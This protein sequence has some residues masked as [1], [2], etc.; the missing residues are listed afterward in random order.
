MIYDKTLEFC[1]KKSVGAAITSDVLDLKQ[2]HPNTG[3][4]TPPFYL[5]LFPLAVSGT[6]ETDAITFTLEDSADNSTFSALLSVTALA[7]S[8]KHAVSIPMPVVHRRYL[9]LTTTITG[10]PKGTL[11]AILNNH[12][13]ILQTKPV[14]GWD[15][16]RAGDDPV[17][18]A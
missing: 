9:R 7:N 12:I 6:S 16:I 1:E 4:C 15:I 8:M 5:V 2:E 14:E 13:E 3:S 18:T 10:T 17:T 11:T